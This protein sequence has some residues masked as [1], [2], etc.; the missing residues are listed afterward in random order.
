MTGYD[1]TN[2]SWAKL[3]RR[4]IARL[5]RMPVAQIIVLLLVAISKLSESLKLR[6]GLQSTGHL[7]QRVVRDGQECADGAR[8]ERVRSRDL[9]DCQQAILKLVVS[10][11][12]G[13]NIIGSEDARWLAMSLQ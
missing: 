12:Q 7:G 6:Q 8:S 10:R 1:V 13:E 11:T 4:R 9:A 5:R 3:S 2:S